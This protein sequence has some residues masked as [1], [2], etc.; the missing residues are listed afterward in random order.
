MDAEHLER[1]AKIEAKLDL[2]VD[3]V[4]CLMR[5][6]KGGTTSDGLTTRVRLNENAIQKMADQRKLI[7]GAL[8]TAAL[9]LIVQVLGD[10]F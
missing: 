5:I 2:I 7:W 6:V 8:L 3:N 10:V 4:G 1:L 9:S